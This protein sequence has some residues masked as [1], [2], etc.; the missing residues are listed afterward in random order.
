M[1]VQWK[2]RNEPREVPLSSKGDKTISRKLNLNAS[3]YRL[4][5]PGRA[6]RIKTFVYRTDFNN[7]VGGATSL[8]AYKFGQEVQ[9]DL[10]PSSN[11]SLTSGLEWVG[12]KVNS[13][14]T[15]FGNQNGLNLAPYLQ[16]EMEAERKVSVSAGGCFDRYRTDSRS[17]ENQFSP[18]FG[19]SYPI[20]A[21]IP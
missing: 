3:Y 12:D 14:P 9:I 11:V 6:Y 16:T 17:A 8:T 19:L 13:T 21:G 4:A 10:Q 5:S 7:Q 15:L 2:D 1:F 18:R 20:T